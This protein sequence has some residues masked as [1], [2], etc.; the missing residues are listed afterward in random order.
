[1]QLNTIRDSFHALGE[2]LRNFLDGEANGKEQWENSLLLA[3]QEN[4]W[5]TQANIRLALRGILSW[6]NR[7]ALNKWLSAYQKL[8]EENKSPKTIGVVMAGNIPLVGFHDFF[9]VLISGNILHAKLSSSDSRLLPFIA[10]KLIAIEPQLKDRIQF[11]DKL[12]R[13]LDA[14]IATG[15]NNTAR[16]FEYYF[17]NVPHIIRRN[18]NGIAVLDGTET[19][20]ELF[21]L[22]K[23]I[24]SYFGLGCR[25]VS[26]LYVPANYNFNHFFEAI[27]PYKEVI[28]HNKYHSN[29]VYNRTIYLMDGKVFTDNGFLA[30]INNTHLSSPIAVLNFEEYES[31]EKIGD[32]LLEIRDTIQCIAVSKSVKAKL[33]NAD[34]P[35]VGIGE[36]QLP[37]LSDYADGVDVIKF[38]L[39]V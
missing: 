34:L 35:F 5:F 18:R 26:K 9:C 12:N 4:P 30:V 28:N 8:G 17:R 31:I 23:D 6:L 11:V 29:Y 2:E 20:E 36:T 24:F 16:H 25:N 38:L 21:E 27:E 22:G 15:S 32:K 33:T 7:D 1:M 37:S 14:V 39:D 10:N 13:P 3:E 19:Q